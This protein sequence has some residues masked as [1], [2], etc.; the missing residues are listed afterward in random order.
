[1][2]YSKYMLEDWTW[3]IWSDVYCPHSPEHNGKQKN[4]P[5]N[6]FTKWI[7]PII[8]KYRLYLSVEWKIN[9]HDLCYNQTMNPA[10][11]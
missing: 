5:T 8:S 11:I 10:I 3:F 6:Q 9:I 4:V 2:K 7:P 1:M